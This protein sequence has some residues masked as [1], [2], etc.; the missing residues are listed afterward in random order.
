MA[1]RDVLDKYERTLTGE[2]FLLFDSRPETTSEDEEEV[3]EEEEQDEG[4]AAAA[5]RRRSPR[6]L[7]F[8]TRRNLELLCESG[9]WFIDGTFK[10]SPIIFTQLFTIMGVRQRN[11][12]NGEEVP[13]PFVYALLSG[14]TEDEYT[15]VLRAVRDAVQQ[16]RIRQCTPETIM[17]DFELAIINSC[18]AVFPD[19]PLRCCFFHLGQAVYGHVQ[20]AGLQTLYND[21]ND[22]TIKTDTRM[23]LALAYVPVVHV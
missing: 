1:L 10:A 7:V 23:L 16:Y 14:K 19:A 18:K 11:T 6:T 3:E 17:S 12:F 13:L 8:A 2:K 15:A 22:R 9:T 4:A 21:K 20:S 5:P